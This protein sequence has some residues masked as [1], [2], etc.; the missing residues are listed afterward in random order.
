MKQ[1]RIFYIEF[2]GQGGLYD[3]D[4]FNNFIQTAVLRNKDIQSFKVIEIDNRLLFSQGFKIAE[5][6]GIALD[7]MSFISQKQNPIDGCYFE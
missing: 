5:K 3:L 4:E 7:Y 1:S 6:F 2:S